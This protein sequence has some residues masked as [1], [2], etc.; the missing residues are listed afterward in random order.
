MSFSENGSKKSNFSNEPIRIAAFPTGPIPWRIDWFGD[1]AYPD[2]YERRRQ[3]SVSIY[4]SQVTAESGHHHSDIQRH[5]YVSV[6]TL[7][8]TNGAEKMCAVIV[9]SDP[10][11][12]RLYSTTGQDLSAAW[13]LLRCA[14]EDFRERLD[15]EGEN[16]VE[17]CF[18]DLMFWTGREA[19]H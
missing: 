8:F 11:F 9:E 10:V 14:P 3:P 7:P 13:E 1:I 2:R 15:V 17:K 12:M 16:W 19:I 4:L 6:A 18:S 5:V